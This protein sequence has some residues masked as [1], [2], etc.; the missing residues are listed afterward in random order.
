MSKDLVGFL[1]EKIKPAL[2][3]DGTLLPH[4]QEEYLTP[5]GWLDKGYI[6]KQ[7]KLHMATASFR[8]AVKQVLGQTEFIQ[9][10][11]EDE[12]SEEEFSKLYKFGE[13][14]Y[15]RA[16]VGYAYKLT[17]K[18]ITRET[19]FNVI[20]NSEQPSN[21]IRFWAGGVRKIKQDTTERYETK[22]F[23]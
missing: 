2:Q 4:I 15:A 5:E 22:L 23:S 3:A 14:N 10:P 9:T 12:L 20:I 8:K 21:G 18:V 6:L 16:W 19:V 11:L 7:L 1:E 17:G 13:F